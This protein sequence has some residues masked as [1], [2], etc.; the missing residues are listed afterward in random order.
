VEAFSVLG[1]CGGMPGRIIRAQ[2]DKPAKQK[3]GVRRSRA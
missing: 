1:E 3:V 2:A